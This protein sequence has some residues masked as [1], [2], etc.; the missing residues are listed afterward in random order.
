[1]VREG[2]VLRTGH[3]LGAA[4]LLHLQHGALSV[5]KR[6]ARIVMMLQKESLHSTSRMQVQVKSAL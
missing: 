2:L 3:V 5:T 1:M 6:N 4:P